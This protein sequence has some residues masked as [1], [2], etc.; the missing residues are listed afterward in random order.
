M[1]RL[2]TFHDPEP[3]AAPSLER[4]K[5]VSIIKDGVAWLA[6]PLPLL[7]FLAHRLWLAALGYAVLA[8]AIGLAI[9]ELPL[10]PEAGMLMIAVLHIGAALEAND[11]RRRALRR[12]GRA[13]IAISA[14]D[15]AEAETRFFTAW[16]AQRI[17]ASSPVV[18]APPSPQQNEPQVIGLFPRPEGAR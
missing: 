15:R 9:K 8:V 4:A 3:H 11:I 10:S 14:P 13:E 5:G 6:L 1:A 18:A 7:W 2:W 16:T 12:R 17:E